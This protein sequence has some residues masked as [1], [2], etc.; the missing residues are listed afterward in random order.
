MKRIQRTEIVGDLLLEWMTIFSIDDGPTGIVKVHRRNGESWRYILSMRMMAADELQCAL[1]KG[2]LEIEAV[3]EA[4]AAEP[5]DLPE[6]DPSN[7]NDVVGAP[8]PELEKS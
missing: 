8:D 3:C 7:V 4:N 2:V 5:E 6:P 1:R